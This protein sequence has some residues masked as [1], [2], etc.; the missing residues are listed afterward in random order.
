MTF[1]AAIKFITF[2]ESLILGIL[3]LSHNS[4]SKSARIFASYAFFIA[5]AAFVEY[6]LVASATAK[7]FS[8]WKHFD[9]CMYGVVASIFHFSLLLANV[10]IAY[11]KPPIILLYV[12]FG[13]FFLIDGFINTPRAIE[14]GHFSFVARYSQ[15][16][17]ILHT[18]F[19]VITSVIAFMVLINFFIF[20]KQARDKRSKMQAILL[21]STSLFLV[22]IGTIAELGVA[23]NDRT[24]LP[25]SLTSTS[26]F[27]LLNPVL[28]F[29]VLRYNIH[30]ITPDLTMVKVME[31]LA[32]A[33]IITDQ[34]GQISFV[35]EKCREIFGEKIPKDVRGAFFDSL[36]VATASA[37][38][39]EKLTFRDIADMEG[40]S[41]E[42]CLIDL[43]ADEVVP[44]SVSSSTLSHEIWGILGY[45][46]TIRDITERWQTEQ[47]HASVE[48]TLR[49]DLKNTLSGVLSGVTMLAA[50][51]S[52]SEDN[53]EVLSV[54]ENCTRLMA[55]QI[56]M[57]KILRKIEER[58][59]GY[60]QERFDLY[61]LLKL[62]VRNQTM[63]ASNKRV[64]LT[65]NSENNKQLTN[66][67]MI[68]DGIQS[69][70]FSLFINVIKNAIESA[71]ENTTVTITVSREAQKRV[72]VHNDGVIPEEIRNGL[73]NEPV[74][75]QKGNRLGIG[76]MSARRIIDA[77]GY[78]ISF[79]SNYADGT[80]VIIGFPD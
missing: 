54:V 41:D 8:F 5:G 55:E 45:A 31:R 19:V 14:P 30:T 52:I 78:K 43:D 29:G 28:A 6:E 1:I 39:K 4:N 59:L 32:D 34:K 16:G 37:V 24:E 36:P 3:C 65:L 70:V 13:A 68:I 23:L 64:Y 27:L 72:S 51:D 77:L 11:E 73:F 67:E 74:A 22:I 33:L 9:Y 76:S 20:L 40:L 58:P 44:V 47:M 56:D 26:A 79:D 25:L 50:E 15:G 60:T 17:E 63:Y 2:I 46:I 7:S 69:L 35:N 80:T 66:G 10:K 21:F 48:R 12:I 18:V 57:Y 53:K 71:S 62:V 61:S 42:M 75:S 38:G 49:H